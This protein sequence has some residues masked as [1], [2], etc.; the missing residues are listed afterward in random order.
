[1][2]DR[3]KFPRPKLCGDTIN[4]G[5]LALLRR[6]GMADPVEPGAIALNGMIVTGEHGIS[7]RSDYGPNV[8]ALSIVRHVLDAAL[9]G[10]ATAAGA[11]FE[12]G[13]LVRGTLV[14]ETPT[15]RVR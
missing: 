8:H 15:P 9:V 12:D 13:V 3:A 11:R 10:A 5:T 6:L 4:P 7:V 2:L 14:D 1:M